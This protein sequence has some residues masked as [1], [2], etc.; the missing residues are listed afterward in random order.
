LPDTTIIEKAP[1]QLRSAHHPYRKVSLTGSDDWKTMSFSRTDSCV[2]TGLENF[3]TL[4]F[5]EQ[6]HMLHNIQGGIFLAPHIRMRM[7]RDGVWASTALP[8]LQLGGGPL[9][10]PNALPQEL[11]NELSLIDF[12]FDFEYWAEINEIL[13]RNGCNET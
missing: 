3:D 12:D 10:N 2:N 13:R 6:Y 9:R 8:A 4:P 5:K 1:F 7:I 11:G